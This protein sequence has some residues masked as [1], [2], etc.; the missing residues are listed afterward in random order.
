MEHLAELKRVLFTS[1]LEITANKDEH[2]TGGSRWLAINGGDAVLALLKR[3]ASEL[4]DDVLRPL[5]LLAFESQH[6]SFLVEIRQTGAIRV[7]QS[8]VVLHERLRY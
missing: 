8:V 1:K 2:T 5:D 7:E 4:R 3:E 6:G